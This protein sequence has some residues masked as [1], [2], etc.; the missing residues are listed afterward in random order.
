MS[1]SLAELEEALRGVHGCLRF[2]PGQFYDCDLLCADKARSW[3]HGRGKSIETAVR[4]ALQRKQ[5][6]EQA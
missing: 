1:A 6:K 2:S 3:V 5:D 4:T